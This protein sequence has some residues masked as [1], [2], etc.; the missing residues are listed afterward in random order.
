MEEFREQEE[1]NRK[2][3]DEIRARMDEERRLTLIE[4]KENLLSEDEGRNKQH[5]STS[6]GSRSESSST[7]GLST[8]ASS[9]SSTLISHRPLADV[10]VPQR[11]YGRQHLSGPNRAG[12]V[13]KPSKY[14][15]AVVGIDK[16]TG[17]TDEAGE[18]GR[19]HGYDYDED[20]DTGKWT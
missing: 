10:P 11:G 19:R 13:L 3:M 4:E 16:I 17:I 20:T 15:G 18:H 1:M 9:S 5:H 8:R 2:E 6:P 12:R 14:T 7:R